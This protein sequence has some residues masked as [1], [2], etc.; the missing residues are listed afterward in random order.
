MNWKTCG[1]ILVE[2]RSKLVVLRNAAL[3]RNKIARRQNILKSRRDTKIVVNSS[4]FQ[5][6]GTSIRQDDGMKRAVWHGVVI[7]L[8]RRDTRLPRKKGVAKGRSDKT[9]VVSVCDAWE[10]AVD[11]DRSPVGKLK[12]EARLRDVQNNGAVP[13]FGIPGRER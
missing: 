10:L 13:G 3:F 5:R 7:C 12:C 11:Y 9:L 1:K 6:S 8:L 4:T 2:R